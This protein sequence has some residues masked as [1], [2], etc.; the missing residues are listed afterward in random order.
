MWKYTWLGSVK[1]LCI[2]SLL[3]LLIVSLPRMSVLQ[4]WTFF[5]FERL[6][7]KQ[8]SSFY[9]LFPTCMQQLG[10]ESGTR[11]VLSCGELE[12][13][14]LSHHHL[15]H[16]VCLKNSG[17]APYH[18]ISGF[19]DLFFYSVCHFYPERIFCGPFLLSQLWL[20]FMVPSF[21]SLVA[22]CSLVLHWEFF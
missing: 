4:T 12:P 2:I 13:E 8:R 20:V 16:R 17:S 15:L 14:Y 7:V 11:P 1:S 10:L 5:L 19:L 18:L 6:R 9:C 22:V 21:C 3:S